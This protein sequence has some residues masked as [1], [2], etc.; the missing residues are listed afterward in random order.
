LVLLII[1][2]C[3]TKPE[4]PTNTVSKDSRSEQTGDGSTLDQ[5]LEKGEITIAVDDT[6]PPMNYRNDI[7]KTYKIGIL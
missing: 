7:F 2:A 6:F 4:L 3:G 1:S 5:I